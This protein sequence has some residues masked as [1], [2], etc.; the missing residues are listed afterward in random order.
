MRQQGPHPTHFGER[1]PTGTGS[2]LGVPCRGI[3]DLKK[4]EGKFPN[5]RSCEEVTESEGIYII[6]FDNGTYEMPKEELLAD[7]CKRCAFPNPLVYD[8]LL[9][10]LVDPKGAAYSDIEEME[11]MAIGEKQEYWKGK[12]SRCLRC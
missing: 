11:K 9:E 6:R 4:I 8:V 3:I 12:F 2:Y 1:N 7:H 10:D 5:A